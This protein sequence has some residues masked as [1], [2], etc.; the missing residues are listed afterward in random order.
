MP[1]SIAMYPA[2]LIICSFEALSQAWKLQTIRADTGGQITSIT[3]LHNPAQL[4]MTNQMNIFDQLESSADQ[5][6]SIISRSDRSGSD[7]GARIRFVRPSRSG[8]PSRSDQDRRRRI[9][10]SL[11]GKDGHLW[12]EWFSLPV[13]KPI[14]F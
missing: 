2:S 12:E 13:I 6:Q 11:E 5:D 1:G 7:P 14:D 9:S 10:W 3:T 8:H 4:Q